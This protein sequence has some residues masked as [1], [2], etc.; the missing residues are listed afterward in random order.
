MLFESH[1]LQQTEEFAAL[2][3]RSLSLPA[4]IY[5]EGDLGAGKTTLCQ[6]IIGELGYQGAVTSPTYNLIQE[7]RVDS[8]MAYHMDLYRLEDPSEIE[9][10]AL[11][12]LWSDKS[13]FLIEWPGK[14][15]QLLPKPT[16][17]IKITDHHCED[18]IFKQFQLT[19]I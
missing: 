13:L 19:F 18:S 12:D 16:H 1:S 17:V 10:L 9:Y 7:Y 8:G 11:A 3:C 4:C 6:L 5:F 2:I 14:G 15:G